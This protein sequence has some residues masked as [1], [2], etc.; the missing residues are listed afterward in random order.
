VALSVELFVKVR[1]L[2]F[3]C[4]DAIVVSLEEA[5]H[6]TYIGNEIMHYTRPLSL[7]SANFHYAS[8]SV[9]SR[10]V[11]SSMVASTKAGGSKAAELPGSYCE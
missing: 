4:V 6:V 9:S 7:H 8:F 11:R 3:L 1:K 5:L 10:A 2:I